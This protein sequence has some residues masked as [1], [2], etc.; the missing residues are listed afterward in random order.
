[1]LDVNLVGVI[2]VSEGGVFVPRADYG[3]VMMAAREASTPVSPGELEIQA[4]VTVRYQ[5][6][7]KR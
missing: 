1:V 2:E 3:G 5:I 4:S 7:N 6:A